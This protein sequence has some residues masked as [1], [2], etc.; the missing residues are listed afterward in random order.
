MI[1]SKKQSSPYFDI[2]SKDQKV[3]I[4]CTGVNGGLADTILLVIFD[5]DREHVDMISI[6]RDTY[7]YREGYNSAAEGKINAAYRKDINNTAKAVSDLLF[8]I[9]I[10]YYAIIDFEGV[11]N[12]VESIGG[13]PMDIPFHMRYTDTNKTIFSITG[14]NII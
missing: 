3:N 4:L 9:P 5:I 14:K 1:L 7:Y 12:I 13:V 6:P 8:G 10:H 2:F 11:A